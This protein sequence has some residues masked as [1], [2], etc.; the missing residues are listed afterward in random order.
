MSKILVF[1][2]HRDGAFRKPALETTSA[3]VKLAAEH[4]LTVSVL[5]AGSG[6]GE[7]AAGLA[8]YGVNEILAADDAKLTA[9]GAGAYSKVLADAVRSEG[10]SLVMMAASTVGKELAPMVAARLGVGLAA[11]V[12]EIGFS[13]G[14]LTAKR[15]VY[16]GKGFVNLQFN[17][18]VQV[19]S[20][21]PNTY[22]VNETGGAAGVKNIAVSLGDNDLRSVVKEIKIKESKRPELTEASVI[23]SGGRGMAGPEN[24][25]VIETLADLL[26]AAVGASRAAVDAGWRPHSDQVG[27]TGKTVSPNLYVACGISGAIQHLAGM[28]SSKYIVAINKDPEAPIF[29]VADYGVV[30]DLFQ[31]VPAMVAELK[32]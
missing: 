1:A 18:A 13:N 23:V 28:S 17:G 9:Y 8:K 5:V 19:A 10:A 7:L 30:G 16:A 29:K 11:D 31:V 20:I 22:P 24:Y 4:G 2:E 26:G 25:V 15:P 27:Q 14:K 21:R 6:V 12:T 3:A 32:K